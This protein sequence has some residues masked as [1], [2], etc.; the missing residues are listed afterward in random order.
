MKSE[1]T[2][3]GRKILV[4]EDEK[5]IRDMLRFA[6]ERADFLIDE[7]EDVAS[8]N[9]YLAESRPDLILLDWM[10]PKISGL[11]FAK[12][13]RSEAIY[14]D[15]P[16]IML[17]ARGEEH[18]RVYGL[19]LGCDDYVTKPFSTSELIARVNAVLRRCRDGGMDET[20]QVEGLMIDT[21]AQRVLANG[22]SLHLGPT[23]YRL[24]NFFAGHPER[25]YTR[26]QLLDRVWG[27]SVY[28]E[29]RTVDVHI[30]RL[31]KALEPHGFD[32]YVQT[33][34]GT[35]YRFSKQSV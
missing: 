27:R 14:K 22:E 13:L 30:R 21:A 9:D 31:R 25:V 33:V 32:H 23:E 18:D 1:Q 26:E 5:A 15:L 4:V 16:I 29:E 35:G 28:V 19:E 10:L 12:Q 2:T 6:L 34:R 8:A 3:T 24:L 11:E 17:T 7:A 20:V